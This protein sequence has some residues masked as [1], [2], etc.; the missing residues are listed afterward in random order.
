MDFLARLRA[1]GGIVSPIL[2]GLGS[3]LGQLLTL[4]PCSLGFGPCPKQ[5]ARQSGNGGSRKLKLYSWIE[6]EVGQ[7]FKV[8]RLCLCRGGPEGLKVLASTQILL[9]LITLEY[10][11][12]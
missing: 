7:F 12:L 5:L 3:G 4:S 9:L 10:S 1:L 2:W 11:W 6:R 8:L